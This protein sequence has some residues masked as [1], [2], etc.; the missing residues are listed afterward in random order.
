VNTLKIMSNVSDLRLKA[1]FHTYG[2]P[3]RSG[4]TV[5]EYEPET[6]KAEVARVVFGQLTTLFRFTALET[7]V[8]GTPRRITTLDTDAESESEVVLIP[9]ICGG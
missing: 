6:E 9:A 1:L 2:I 7:T 4:H 3:V 5:I 8:A